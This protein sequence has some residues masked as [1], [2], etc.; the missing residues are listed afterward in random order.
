MNEA[1]HSPEHALYTDP[2]YPN[3]EYTDP[4]YWNPKCSNFVVMDWEKWERLNPSPPK[5]FDPPQGKSYKGIKFSPL[6]WWNRSCYFQLL[7]CCLH[8]SPCSVKPE[9][10][11]ISGDVLVTKILGKHPDSENIPEAL[12]NNLLWTENNI[13]PET[14]VSV[15]RFAWR[16]QSEEGRIIGLGKLVYDWT[17]D[18]SMFGFGTSCFM[19]TRYATVQ[20]S[21]DGRW[22]LFGTLSDPGPKGVMNYIYFYVVQKGEQYHTTDGKLMEHV[23]PGDLVRVTWGDGSDPYACD[24][25]DLKYFY[26]PRKVATLDEKTGVVHKNHEHYNDLLKHATNKP[27]K[28]V[29]TCCYTCS[30]FMS[31]EDRFHF[32]VSNISDRQVFAMSPEPPSSQ[33]LERL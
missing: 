9:M 19:K 14:L 6:W 32:Q 22:I 27:G 21:P 11:R 33:V 30:C 12:R 2:N 24:N 15:N 16:S 5:I 10:E 8:S 7:A 28:C 18:A 20:T 4:R 31:A 3:P 13:A 1:A 23:K 26:F 17:N 29:E 25:K